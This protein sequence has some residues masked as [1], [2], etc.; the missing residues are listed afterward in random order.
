MKRLTSFDGLARVIVAPYSSSTRA[1]PLQKNL[2]RYRVNRN[3]YRALLL[4]VRPGTLKRLGEPLKSWLS[5]QDALAG[6]IK[7]LQ[8]EGANRSSSEHQRADGGFR[9]RFFT[10]L[11][12]LRTIQRRSRREQET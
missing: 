10:A 8:F 3:R 12:L 9:S 11:T 7:S 1:E 6:K 5:R 4:A 2:K